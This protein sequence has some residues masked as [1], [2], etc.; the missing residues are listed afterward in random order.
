MKLHCEICARY[1]PDTDRLH[2]GPHSEIAT[3]KEDEIRL[4]LDGSM[5]ASPNPEREVPAPWQ[6]GVPWDRLFCPRGG[7]LIF[8]AIPGR[9]QQAMEQGGPD[10]ILTD[11][12]WLDLTKI[13]T[14]WS[15]P[16][17]KVELVDDE[18]GEPVERDEAIRMLREVDPKIWTYKALSEKYG[19]SSERIRQIVKNV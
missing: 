11:K 18:T 10:K 8:L 5:F 14:Q 15:L 4:P 7:H 13:E 19:V 12:G 16:P 1:E 3:I 2:Q 9:M 6:A 17:E